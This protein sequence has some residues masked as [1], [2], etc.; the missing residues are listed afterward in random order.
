MKYRVSDNRYAVNS[1]VCQFPILD[2][3]E[4]TEGRLFEFCLSLLEEQEL[5]HRLISLFEL[6]LITSPSPQLLIL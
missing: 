6:T 1:L 4:V 5:L 3:S 2:Y